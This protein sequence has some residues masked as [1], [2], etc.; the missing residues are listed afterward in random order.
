LAVGDGWFAP[1]RDARLAAAL[2]ASVDAHSIWAP[3]HDRGELIDLVCVYMTPSGYQLTGRRADELIGV[4]IVASAQTSGNLQFAEAMLGVARSGVAVR[5]RMRLLKR[6]GE[7]YW[8]DLV[9]V[10]LAGGLSLNG[11][12]VTA[13]VYLQAE[14]K[15]TVADLARLADTDPLTGLGNRRT[16]TRRLSDLMHTASVDSAPLIVALLDLDRF[17]SYNDTHGH[18]AGDEL[19]RELASRWR[20]ALPPVGTL[21]RIGGEEFAVALPYMELSAAREV[22][23]TLCSLVPSGQTCSAGMT[24]WDGKEDG[25]S[26][27]GRADAALYAAKRGGRN[28]IEVPPEPDHI[29]P[30][31]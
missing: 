28:R 7:P 9:A 29:V 3:V 4:R 14:L 2:E 30:T 25:T 15:R 24:A 22:L 10:E 17:K 27:L 1:S 20:K 11:R 18:A 21:A 31:A 26:V 23:V 6:T 8:M 13:E 12:D 5:R 16:W 19:L